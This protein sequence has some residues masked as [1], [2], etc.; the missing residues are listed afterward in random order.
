[1]S[2]KISAASTDRNNNTIS[3]M[4]CSYGIAPVVTR[5]GLK[6]EDDERKVQVL[7]LR[8]KSIGIIAERKGA[9]AHSVK[10]AVTREGA[11][12]LSKLLNR[13]LRGKSKRWKEP[14]KMLWTVRTET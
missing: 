13:I 12:V 11:M 3:T 6:H 1:M 4:L 10:F 5:V 8:G 2:K 14:A 7:R 9:K